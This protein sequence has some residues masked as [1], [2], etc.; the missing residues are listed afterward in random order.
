MIIMY[1]EKNQAL[2]Y[3]LCNLIDFF[4]QHKKANQ[5]KITKNI[6]V[7]AVP[8]EVQLDHSELDQDQVNDRNKTKEGDWHNDFQVNTLDYN[9]NGCDLKNIYR[10]NCSSKEKKTYSH[11]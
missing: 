3:N 6:S 4:K 1:M 7:H 5:L 2:I 9:D 10:N 8:C 11:W